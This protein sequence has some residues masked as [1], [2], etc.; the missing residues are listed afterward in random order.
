MKRIYLILI[1]CFASVAMIN[2][3]ERNIEND[4]EIR[5]MNGFKCEKKY[6]NGKLIEQYTYNILENIEKENLAKDVKIGSLKKILDSA[7]LYLKQ[8]EWVSSVTKLRSFEKE[9]SKIFG[10]G[11]DAHRTVIYE[12]AL[13]YRDYIGDYKKTIDVFYELVEIHKN[14][15][16]HELYLTTLLR[17]ANIY[18]D[19]L[20]NYKKA[21]EIYYEITEIAKKNS[22][23]ELYIFALFSIARAYDYGENFKESVEIYENIV[24]QISEISLFYDYYEY[25]L[26]MIGYNYIIGI[27]DYEKAIIAYEEV[28]KIQEEKYGK[29]SNEF[30]RTLFYIAEKYYRFIQDIHLSIKKLSGLS[31]ILE[32][33]EDISNY[34]YPA[35]DHRVTIYTYARLLS[36]I[37][38]KYKKL[39]DKDN[40]LKY[41]LKKLSLYD[42]EDV[43]YI[44]TLNEVIEC[45]RF[46]KDY[47]N[48]LI[49]YEKIIDVQQ[50]F[51]GN[52]S[53]EYITA[54]E[55]LYWFLERDVEDHS[56]ALEY[57]N[58]I[59]NIYKENNQY[60]NYIN[61]LEE[62]DDQAISYGDYTVYSTSVGKYLD[63]QEYLRNKC[64]ENSEYYIE[65]LKNLK[66]KYDILNDTLNEQK[67]SSEINRILLSNL[68]S[69]KLEN[70]NFTDYISHLKKIANFITEKKRYYVLA[71]GYNAIMDGYYDHKKVESKF[72]IIRDD[73]NLLT[74]LIEKYA[75]TKDSIDAI[76][77]EYIKL[78]R[79]IKDNYGMLKDTLTEQKISSEIDSILFSNLES[80]KL[81]NDEYLDYVNRLKIFAA[82]FNIK[83]F[84]NGFNKFNQIVDDYKRLK[85]YD[86]EN[87]WN[88]LTEFGK[89]Y[90]FN[91][92]G[93][94]KYYAECAE[95]AYEN[96]NIERCPYLLYQVSRIEIREY[97]MVKI[98]EKCAE[99]SKKINNDGS[100]YAFLSK[101]AEYYIHTRDY[102]LAID[103]YTDIANIFFQ[104]TEIYLNALEYIA[105]IYAYWL[106]DNELQNNENALI[107]C[108]KYEEE[109]I[110]KE[111]YGKTNAMR[112]IADIYY[113]QKD[114][115][116]AMNYYQ[117]IVIE[118]MNS[119]TPD[120]QECFGVL[121]I[122]AQIL[123]LDEEETIDNKI[124]ECS[125]ILDIFENHPTPT[126]DRG[127]FQ[128][129]KY[130][131]YLPVL[132]V[133][134]ESYYAK[135]EY[136]KVVDYSKRLF[137]AFDYDSKVY[138][139]DEYRYDIEKN[140]FYDFIINSLYNLGENEEAQQY[141]NSL[142][143]VIK[144]IVTHH[145]Y[146]N[147][148][149]ERE[150]FWNQNQIQAV[151][152][153]GSIALQSNDFQSKFIGDVFNANLFLRGI[154]LNS[155]IEL[156]KILLES[157]NSDIIS[158]YNEYKAVCEYITRENDDGSLYEKRKK[159]EEKL[160]EMAQTL[161]GFM[162]FLNIQWQDIQTQLRENELAVDFINFPIPKD[163]IMY[164]ALLL[165]KD[166]EYPKF[167][168]LWSEQELQKKIGD[169]KIYNDTFFGRMIWEPVLKHIENDT[170]IYFSV[171]GLLHKIPIEYLPIKDSITLNER[172]NIYRL[173]SMRQLMDREKERNPQN[174][175]VLFGGINYNANTKGSLSQDN[176]MKS[177]TLNNTQDNLFQESDS[178][179][180]ELLVDAILRGSMRAE[181]LHGAK[182]EVENIAQFLSKEN[183]KL[184]V[185]QGDT[186][187]KTS[188]KELSGKKIDIIHIATH[189]FYLTKEEA[190]K[191]KITA[192][193]GLLFAGANH[194]LNK[195]M[196]KKDT[197][198]VIDDGILI[199]EEVSLMDLRD[200]DLVVLSACQTG[201]GEITAEGVFGL[202]RGF[203]KAGVQTIIM[204]LW[205]V[206]DKATQI[207]MTEFYKEYFKTG[208]KHK[209]FLTAQQNLKNYSEEEVEREEIP[210]SLETFDSVEQRYKKVYKEKIVKKYPYKAPY[211][212]AAFILLD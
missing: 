153:A 42:N 128:G 93:A 21:I 183:V 22:N 37:G 105:K 64:G 26:S 4:D 141:Y 57:Y 2:A 146:Y 170:I 194:S 202:Q 43:E 120:D 41:F 157:G 59:A 13:I 87:Y 25:A 117:K 32:E 86:D 82:N 137:K 10:L 54:L 14:S 127:Y 167:V 58:K 79:K 140:I 168:P 149:V 61:L 45:L 49:Y 70:G 151:Y 124:K 40:S 60:E 139:R 177:D 212:W 99:L 133:L 27:G 107:A 90:E 73:I 166:W 52:N 159:L 208:D 131:H 109:C 192:Q 186:A 200:V 85:N 66:E 185:F 148:E 172:Y 110:K 130:H 100:Y 174:A 112:M 104:K 209:A 116:K 114:Y 80:I 88:G 198:Q 89:F 173:S 195:G 171:S 204:S 155:S 179:R 68:E 35:N 56:K 178:T 201:L 180:R 81:E 175:A 152:L 122:I 134:A 9:V 65:L 163:T 121:R 38:E 144:K 30:K 176:E 8:D 106:P 18:E 160:I 211:F 39:D 188:F 156:N 150:K 96:K 20:N 184:Q 46:F 126:T 190:E 5:Y 15:F 23:K 191:S 75:I 158:C 132:H 111:H 197:I 50:S 101:I 48:C 67:I 203:K 94:V 3:Q 187:T 34:T 154:L 1:F 72:K 17:I 11:S 210:D 142:M 193:S 169:S 207:M 76:S 147:T 145:F 181:F 102:Y 206:S 196:P 119:I 165:K 115:K 91:L 98:Y 74:N 12:V 19:N 199:D 53:N 36:T 47:Q 136:S 108:K 62:I 97:D 29:N 125:K 55:N 189:G 83:E 135:G 84:S 31:S 143:K 28:I 71:P 182:L 113:K 118:C 164:A 78:L 7:Y 205:K 24:E 6:V 161:G 129:A 51:Y 138:N 95:I 77:V 69:I 162:S 44:S 16:N 92:G 103:K 123:L 63:A 33:I